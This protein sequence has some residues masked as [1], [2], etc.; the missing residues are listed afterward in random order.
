[1]SPCVLHR[2]RTPSLRETTLRPPRA[3]VWWARTV[4]G[5][6]RRCCR[7]PSRPG[8]GSLPTLL[9]RWSGRGTGAS[10]MIREREP[11]RAGRRTILP[12]A[13][14]VARILAG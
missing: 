14:D 5:S 6:G 4:L 8:G 13:W 9:W 10:C 7:R 11:P 1:M 12:R 2:D 3:R